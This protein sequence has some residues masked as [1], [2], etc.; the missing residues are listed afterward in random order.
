MSFCVHFWALNLKTEILS[1]RP[2]SGSFKCIIQRLNGH[3]QNEACL[4]NINM[5]KITEG[6]CST[7]M[8]SYL[9][10][11]N[12]DPCFVYFS[13]TEGQTSY[14]TIPKVVLLLLLF[15]YRCSES[16]LDFHPPSMEL[17]HKKVKDLR[18]ASYNLFCLN[19]T[20]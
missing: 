3:Q 8:V 17:C 18:L 6:S 13:T 12:S 14:C 20:L 10:L 9:Y 5:T 4:C 19:L 15:F 2:R 7:V 16:V 1:C 11:I